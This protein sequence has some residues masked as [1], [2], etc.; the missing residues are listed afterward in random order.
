[1]VTLLSVVFLRDGASAEQ[2]GET[3]THRQLRLSGC[4]YRGRGQRANRRVFVLKLV[5]N[6]KLENTLATTSKFAAMDTDT[7]WAKVSSVM[8]EKFCDMFTSGTPT[9]IYPAR[10]W[11]YNLEVFGP[12]LWMDR[13]ISQGWKNQ[14]G[15]CGLIIWSGCSRTSAPELCSGHVFTSLPASFCRHSHVSH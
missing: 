7:M 12:I 3:T 8:R 5:F 2:W 14:T 11:V 4:V 13:R 15:C 1:M 10:W 9:E 6:M